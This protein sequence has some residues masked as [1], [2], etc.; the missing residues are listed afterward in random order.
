MKTAEPVAPATSSVSKAEPAASGPPPGWLVI[1]AFAAVYLIWGSTYLGIRIAI[2]TL[3]PFLMAGLRFAIAG[4]SLYAV[5]R[6]TGVPR[7]EPIQWR[8]SAIIGALLLFAGNGGVTWAEKRVPSGT[9]ALI[10]AGTS[11]WIIVVDWLR[12]GGRRPHGLVFGGLAL[13]FAGVTL[14]VAGRSDTG[15]ALVDPVGA[16]VLLVAS[17]CWACG[18]VFSRQARQPKSTLLAIAMQMT[19]GGIIMILVGLAAGEAGRFNVHAVSAAS[20]W[21]F[22]YLTVFGS[23]VGFSAYVWLLRV[24]T[25]ARVSTYAYVNPLIAALLGYLVLHEP[26]PGGVLIAGTLI[27]AAVALITVKGAAKSK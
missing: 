16:A 21:A 15:H 2:E 1:A 27:L 3:P 25:P 5:M 24:S 8:D 17:V 12:P 13:G 10:V 22:A 11:L 19:T 20:L 18:S 6:G 9:A 26:L 7:P 23:L 4:L 14:I